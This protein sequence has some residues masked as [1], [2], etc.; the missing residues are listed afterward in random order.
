MLVCERCLYVLLELE[1]LSKFVYNVIK[2]STLE[3]KLRQKVHCTIN[4]ILYLD[5]DYYLGNN[6]NNNNNLISTFCNKERI[7]FLLL[8]KTIGI[9]VI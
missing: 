2:T 7:E 4:I 3:Q 5:L 8:K 9:Y 1:R 6:N